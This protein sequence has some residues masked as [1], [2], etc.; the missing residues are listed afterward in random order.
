MIRLLDAPHRMA[1]RGAL[2]EG[3]AAF[4]VTSLHTLLHTLLHTRYTLL[5]I[6]SAGVTGL[7]YSRAG[8][9]CFIAKCSAISVMMNL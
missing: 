4:A 1:T 2:Q 9:L 5:W 7:I 3:A 6:S 8:L